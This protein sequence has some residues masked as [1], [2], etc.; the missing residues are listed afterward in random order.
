VPIP[1]YLGCPV[2]LPLTRA[3]L[4]VRGCVARARIIAARK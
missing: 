2:P 3:H 4:V 1:L